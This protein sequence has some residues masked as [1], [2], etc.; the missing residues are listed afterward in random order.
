MKTI[1]KNLVQKSAAAIFGVSL[2]G[3]ATVIVGS[4]IHNPNLMCA[5]LGAC[6]GSYLSELLYLK[7]QIKYSYNTK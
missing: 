1:E 3:V 7:N 2:I 4:N 5:G 6:G